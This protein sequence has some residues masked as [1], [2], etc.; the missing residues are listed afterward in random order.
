[1]DKVKA[2]FLDMD[3]TLLN[4][5]NEISEGN[6]KTVKDL[7]DKGYLVFI[8]TGRGHQEIYSI[9]PSGFEVDGLISSNGMTGELKGK[10]L[11]THTLPQP[12]IK[13]VIKHAERLG[14]YYEV[15]SEK[16]EPYALMRDR[17]MLLKT[18]SGEKSEAVGINEWNERLK[19]VNQAISF[20]DV[21]PETGYSK[22]YCFDQDKEKMN[23]WIAVLEE[24]KKTFPFSTSQST[25][26][27]VEIMVEGKNKATGIE[28]ILKAIGVDKSEILV[29]GDSYNDLS[30]FHYADYKV[31]MKQ[32]PEALKKLA[33]DITQKDNN[34]DGVS[35]Y[36]RK[37]FLV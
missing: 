9:S 6:A 29:M 36:L 15:F 25:L 35:D 1:M 5:Q 33:S 8:V 31:A 34:E 4:D 11:F 23:E 26:F 7:R 16:G 13:E 28:E 30:M 20:L 14:V 17:E 12:V 3:G 2:I 10:R 27:N 22:F 19:A 18:I 21:L 37:H 24:L 32:A